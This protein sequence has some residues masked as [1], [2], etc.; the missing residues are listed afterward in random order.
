MLIR[1][2]LSLAEH[3]RQLPFSN[4]TL[5]SGSTAALV[6]EIDPGKQASHH[7]RLQL[8]QYRSRKHSRHR[9]INRKAPLPGLPDIKRDGFRLWPVGHIAVRTLL[10]NMGGGESR[11]NLPRSPPSSFDTCSPQTAQ[12][13]GA[14]PQCSQPPRACVAT[15]K[16]VPSLGTA[17]FPKAG[18]L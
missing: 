4:R 11:G 8:Q 10:E 13:S 2:S 5:S 16:G 14:L 6:F 18:E 15:A 3:S 9:A 12:P 7:H 17:T 1:I